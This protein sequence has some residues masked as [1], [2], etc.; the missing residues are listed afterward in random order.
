M[1]LYEYHCAKCAKDFEELVIG[2]NPKVV[3]PKC[4]G[5]KVTKLMSRFA[6]KS[7]QKFSSSSGS[8]C[9]GCSSS[10]CSSCGH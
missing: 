5:K 1:P 6:H 10:N 7:G 4:G 3:C 9:S 2:S 8:N